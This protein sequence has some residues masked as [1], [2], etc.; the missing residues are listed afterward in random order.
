MSPEQRRE[1]IVAAALPLVAEYGAKVTT[2]QVARVAGIGEATIFRVFADK[3]ELLDAVMAEA[4]RHDHVI[5]EIASIPLDEPLADRLAE[6]AEALSAHLTRLMSVMGALHTSGYRHEQEGAAERQADKGPG[7]V[8]G[9]DPGRG[10]RAVRAGR[11]GAAGAARAGRRDVPGPAVQPGAAAGAVAALTT[12]ELVDTFLYGAVSRAVRGPGRVARTASQRR[13]SPAGR[14]PRRNVRH[15]QNCA[16]RSFLY[17]AAMTDPPPP[18]Q[19]CEPGRARD[20]PVPA[21]AGRA[22]LRERK[23]SPPGRRSGEAAMR[24]AIERGL[25]K[26]LVEDIAAAADVST[27]TFNNYFASKYEAICAL[28]LDRA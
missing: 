9:R 26:V 18:P 16:S 21:S 10:Q 1:M 4:L 24:L 23:S 5:R 3:E 20:K 22:G 14:A 8:D 12:A 2:S 25:D 15:R 6:A 19:P 7:A 11:A 13:A 27:R 17:A 28:M